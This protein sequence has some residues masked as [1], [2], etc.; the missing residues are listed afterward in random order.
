ME[1]L[2]V[3]IADEH[4]IVR[5]GLQELLETDPS[6]T[7]IGGA[8]SVSESLLFLQ[9]HRADV[10]LVDPMLGGGKGI[11]LIRR[12]HHLI[13]PPVSLAVSDAGTDDLI[14]QAFQAGVRGYVTKT[15]PGSELVEAVRRVFR[16]EGALSDCLITPVV[17]ALARL[18]QLQ[19]IRACGFLD[20]ELAILRQLASG[21]TNREIAAQEF[22]SEPTVKRKTHTIYRKLGATDRAGAV[23][24]ALRLGLI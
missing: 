9:S 14:E 24:A 13:D 7:V 2:R 19:S 15:A 8:G 21:A 10:I 16:G 11:E 6:I 5:L 3:F 22:M 20:V 18:A 23:S 4:P 1:R 12:L 17:S